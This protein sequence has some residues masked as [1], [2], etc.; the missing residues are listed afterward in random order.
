MPVELETFII[1][2]YIL[3]DQWYQQHMAPFKKQRGRPA[4]F[5]DSEALTL[6]VVAS[7]RGNVP[8]QSER[9]FLRYM[10]AHFRD[11][12]PHLP[13]RSAFNER[14]RR[15]F[16]VLVELQQWCA[17]QCV[18]QD[19]LY[20]CVDSLPLPAG[21]LGQFSRECGHWLR[22]S[23]IGRGA[24]GWFWGD[25][26]LMS[27]TSR[28][29]ITGWLLGAA[30]LNDRWLFQA[31]VSARAGEIR[32]AEPQRRTKDARSQHLPPPVG[33]IG[34]WRAVGKS[35]GRCYLA[36]RNFNGERWQQQ[37]RQ[38]YHAQVITAPVHNQRRGWSRQHQ[39]WL[40]R[41]RQ[42][43][44]TVFA[45]LSET[46]AI[47]RVQAHSRWGQFTRLAAI[48]AAYQIGFYLNRLLGRPL[49]AL[50]TLIC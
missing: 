3:V 46:F 1:R 8:W 19:E 21:S 35:R 18:G 17:D 14:I 41:H 11:W 9:G 5:S 37:W 16:G 6:A 28:G 26:L 23:T 24:G 50:G 15:L 43:I 44:E 38:T 2:I 48:T 40:N 39:H 32:L 30:H 13:Q 10:H 7:W 42:I 36:D 25:H 27:V 29:V 4:Q 34:A 12:F 47:K 45:I 49:L 31:F 22:E 20:E 33:F